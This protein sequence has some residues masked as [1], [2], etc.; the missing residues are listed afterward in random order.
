MSRGYG[1]APMLIVKRNTSLVENKIVVR[2]QAGASKAIGH[3][4]RHPPWQERVSVRVT[5][6]LLEYISTWAAF[7]LPTTQ[8]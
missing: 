2:V 8:R 5:L 1:C 4:R 3:V 7:A 6:R